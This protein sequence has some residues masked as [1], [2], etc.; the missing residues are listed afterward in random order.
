MEEMGH[1]YVFL[2]ARP[3]EK[4]PA[5]EG[6][7]LRRWKDMIE[8]DVKDVGYEDMVW[9]NRPAEGGGGGSSR[10]GNKTP[11]PIKTQKL[12]E[13]LISYQCYNGFDPSS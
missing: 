6:G 4:R 7:A 10:H 9:V 8:S 12:T 11:S 2:V 3:I 1:A 5:G 13:Q